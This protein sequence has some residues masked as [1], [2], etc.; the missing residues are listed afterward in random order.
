MKTNFNKWM[1][2]DMLITY[3]VEHSDILSFQ[4]QC[5]FYSIGTPIFFM[6]TFS[7]ISVVVTDGWTLS[8]S[9]SDTQVLP[10]L[11]YFCMFYK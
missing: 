7:R 11:P 8:D 9:T 4:T 10:I 5:E 3:N 2:Q 1:L 6:S